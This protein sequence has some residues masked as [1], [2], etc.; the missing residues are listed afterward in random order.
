MRLDLS[1]RSTFDL[2]MATVSMLVQD[3]EA[4]LLEYRTDPGGAITFA[5]RLPDDAW[6]RR[7]IGHR[8]RVRRNKVVTSQVRAHLQESRDLAEQVRAFLE[9]R[10][11]DS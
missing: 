6:Q 5:M 10:L 2:A 8:A 7:V 3:Y 4:S 9:P 1:P 11:P